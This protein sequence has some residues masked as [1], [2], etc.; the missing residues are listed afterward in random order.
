MLFFVIYDNKLTIISVGSEPLRV[1][2]FWAL[3]NSNANPILNL[4]YII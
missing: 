4:F 3:G 1:H 2:N